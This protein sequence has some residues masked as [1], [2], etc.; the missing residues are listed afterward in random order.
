[1]SRILVRKNSTLQFILS[2]EFPDLK[3]ICIVVESRLV[4]LVFFGLLVPKVAERSVDSRWTELTGAYPVMEEARIF[5]LDRRLDITTC[6]KINAL[7]VIKS[8]SIETGNSLMKI[9]M[10]HGYWH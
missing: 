5:P 7:M 9:E 6:I 2:H 8:F 10:G 4:F 1:M 3:T